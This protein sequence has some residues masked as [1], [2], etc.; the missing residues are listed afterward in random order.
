M[1]FVIPFFTV[2]NLI[3]KL[4]KDQI[5]RPQAPVKATLTRCLAMDGERPVAHR[6]GGKEGPGVPSKRTRGSGREKVDSGA[7]KL[8]LNDGLSASPKKVRSALLLEHMLCTTA[9][10][11]SDQTALSVGPC[12]AALIVAELVGVGWLLFTFSLQ[13]T[14]SIMENEDKYN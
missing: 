10:Y 12:K 13:Q 6:R 5:G 2:G 9:L 7:N 14:V 8:D 4:P 1:M 11:Y 3:V